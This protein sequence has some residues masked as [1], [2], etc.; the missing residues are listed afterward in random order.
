[1]NFHE[2][3]ALRKNIC[4]RLFVTPNSHENDLEDLVA[5]SISWRLLIGN[6]LTN[7]NHDCSLM[8]MV[9]SWRH[10]CD[11]IFVRVTRHGLFS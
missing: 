3:E 11:R 7:I 2:L 9:F 8:T 1:M 4:G 5:Q 6:T 10:I